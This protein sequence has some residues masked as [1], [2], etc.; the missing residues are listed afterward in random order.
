MPLRL[1]S[2]RQ[3]V[4]THALREQMIVCRQ[5]TYRIP[6]PGAGPQGDPRQRGGPGDHGDGYD[7]GGAKRGDG[8]AGAADSPAPSGQARGHCQRLRVPGLRGSV[9]HHRRGLKRGWDGKI[10][11]KIKKAGP[12]PETLICGFQSR[13]RL[14][15]CLSL[16]H[17]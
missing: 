9:L 14:L 11:S 12:G 16:I 6:G 1:P 10:I 15:L 13:N 5:R 8:S 4:Q 2:R 3:L 7:E 17:I